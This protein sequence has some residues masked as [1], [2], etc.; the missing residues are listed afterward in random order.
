MLNPCFPRGSMVGTLSSDLILSSM[1]D[2]AKLSQIW[3]LPARGVPCE[4][5][6][7]SLAGYRR[8][9]HEASPHEGLPCWASVFIELLGRSWDVEV[10]QEQVDRDT[11]VSSTPTVAPRSLA[12][13]RALSRERR[14]RGPQ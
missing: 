9:P 14:V 11:P 12:Y 10:A 1:Q 4:E 3:S 6:F 7:W 2:C 13:E 8:S 5:V